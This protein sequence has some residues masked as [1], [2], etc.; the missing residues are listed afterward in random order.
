M[1][2]I[3]ENNILRVEIS[4]FGAEIQSVRN[5]VTGH[6]YIWQGDP[7]FWKR[8]SPVLFPIVGSVWDGA[9]TMDGKRWPMGQHGFARD[10][11]FAA[12]T[13]NVPEDEAW[14]ELEADEATL[15]LYPRR[16]RLGIGYRLEQERLT[17]MWRVSNTDTRPMDFQIGGHPAFNYPG[18]CV[19]D[20]V[21]A[22]LMTDARTLTSRLIAD[23]GCISAE[24][25]A[26]EKDAD[27]LIPVTAATFD[28]NTI[29]LEGGQV[30]RISLLT[31]EHTPYLSLL[32]DAPVAGIWS[33]SADA[34]F[35][36]IEPWYGRCDTV[37]FSG[38]FAERE[39]TNTLAPGE[40][41]DKSYIIIFEN[42]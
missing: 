27:G 20:P 14:F 35:I 9:F 15:A 25:M 12:M 17:V 24:T 33:P 16:F 19:S 3:L 7:R 21:R 30:R 11:E 39:W 8:R 18:F 40:T 37:G 32:F 5:K 6:E 28:I 23:K 42:I 13:E 38:D 2:Q 36:C 4:S 22:Y 26:V 10:S 34:P 1:I 31:K 29:M 41:F